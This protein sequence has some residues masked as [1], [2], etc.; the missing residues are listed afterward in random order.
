MFRNEARIIAIENEN[1]N[2]DFTVTKLELRTH[3]T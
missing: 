1:K 3:L 2:G